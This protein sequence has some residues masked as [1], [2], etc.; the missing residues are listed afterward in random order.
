MADGLERKKEGD[1]SP[2][3][4]VTVTGIQFELTRPASEPGCLN[5]YMYTSLV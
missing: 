4:V 1:W 5:V 3:H 2:R